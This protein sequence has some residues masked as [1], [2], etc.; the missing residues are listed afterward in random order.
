MTAFE[1]EY[2]PAIHKE[3]TRS[4]LYMD[5]LKSITQEIAHF[6]ELQPLLDH[7]VAALQDR[8]HFQIAS[9]FHYDDVEQHAVLVAQKG[10]NDY[11]PL[12][13]VQAVQ[14]GLLG[15][16]LREK[17]TLLVDDTS[18]LPDY[19]PP[20]GYPSACAEL[21]VPIF[22][23]S[24]GRLWGAFN[25]EN[26]EP[27][28][29]SY[30]D[31]SAL[32]LIATQLGSAIYSLDLRQQEQWML[33]E[34]A[35]HANRQQ[36]LLDQVLEL[37]TPAF[38]VYPG[39]LAVPM[40]GTLDMQRM[41]YTTA[42]L[43][44]EIQRTNCATIILDMTGITQLD[45]TAAQALSNLVQAS[46]LLGAKVIVTGIRPDVARTLVTLDLRPGSMVIRQTF[47]CGLQYALQ[48]RGLRIG[49]A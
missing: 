45:T 10:Q 23:G 34:L 14:T 28:S 29:F 1:R 12:G 25:V 33:Y 5:V 16:T 2:A 24:E 38:P 17:Q 47:G 49:A 26:M 32:E 4:L 7:V 35:Q 9:I 6:Q 11:E 15:R 30:Y 36:E 48:Q 31:Q 40:V 37:S 27:G 43:L 39:V 42:T 3:E 18:L 13:Y 22:V 46:T 20:Q 21:C 44:A 19:I 41:E 8:L